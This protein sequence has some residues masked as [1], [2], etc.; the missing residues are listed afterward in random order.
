MLSVLCSV[1]RWREERTGGLFTVHV[2]IPA[3]GC[4]CPEDC[5]YRTGELALVCIKKTAQE[6]SIRVVWR[7]RIEEPTNAL[8]DFIYLKLRV[9]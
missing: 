5:V 4:H 1:R 2:N 9:S 3:F 8:A 7:E 6:V